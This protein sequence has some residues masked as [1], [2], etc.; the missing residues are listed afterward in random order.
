MRFWAPLAPES[1]P[2]SRLPSLP[3]FLRILRSTTY[4]VSSWVTGGMWLKSSYRGGEAGVDR[5]GFGT[6]ATSSLRLYRAGL[7]P[8][9]GVASDAIQ[10]EPH[11]CS[12]LS[13]LLLALTPSLYKRLRLANTNVPKAKII[14]LKDL[15]V[16]SVVSAD[17]PFTYFK[18]V[19]LQQIFQYHSTEVASEVL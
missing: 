10:K 3:A 7:A 6:M 16:T 5:A 15:Y 8:P 18:N 2:K 4:L 11:G 17:L 19:F 13:P 9:S 12:A 1:R 14:T